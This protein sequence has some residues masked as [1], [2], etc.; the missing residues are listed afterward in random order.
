MRLCRRELPEVEEEK[1]A[2]EE[3]SDERLTDSP[4]VVV[5]IAAMG[6][7]QVLFKLHWLSLGT[8]ANPSAHEP[9]VYRL[10]QRRWAW[11]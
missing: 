1:E 4:V 8:I 7:A 5:G 6:N 9:R 3:D 11:T 2:E 10:R